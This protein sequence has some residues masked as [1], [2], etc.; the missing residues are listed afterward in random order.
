[1]RKGDEVEVVEMAPEE[2]CAREMFVRVRS[3]R[4]RLGPSDKAGQENE[5]EELEMAVPLA[6]LEPTTKADEETKKA[7]AE[8][9]WWVAEGYRF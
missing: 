4:L 7:V 2:E 5:G 8:W 3:E 6:Q 1:L 9:R